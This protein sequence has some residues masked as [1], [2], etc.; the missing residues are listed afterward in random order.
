MSKYLTY[1]S[2]GALIGINLS[3]RLLNLPL[4]GNFLIGNMLGEAA[5][6]LAITTL[7]VDLNFPK[8]RDYRN[9]FIMLGIIA[10]LFGVI[11]ELLTLSSLF[12][13]SNI[14]PIVIAWFSIAPVIIFGVGIPCLYIGKRVMREKLI[15]GFDSTNSKGIFFTLLFCIGYTI[16]AIYF[17]IKLGFLAI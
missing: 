2:I 13:V 6:F 5:A 7:L 10:I 15:F 1:S 12:L 4:E 14:T 8:I 3:A 16:A 11:Y 9:N 17:L